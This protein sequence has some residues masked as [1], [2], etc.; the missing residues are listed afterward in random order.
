MT[1][2]GPR[3]AACCR[4]SRARRPVPDTRRLADGCRSGSRSACLHRHGARHVC[5][6][7]VLGGHLNFYLDRH[8]AATDTATLR[9]VTIIGVSV[10]VSFS[11][12]CTH[13]SSRCGYYLYCL[14]VTNLSSERKA[15][16]WEK[17]GIFLCVYVWIISLTP[18]KSSPS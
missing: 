13:S 10:S 17:R 7:R 2:R 14:A 9:R 11:V 16:C 5:V 4:P 3:A 1:L 12:R 15:R 18:H 8:T 6:C